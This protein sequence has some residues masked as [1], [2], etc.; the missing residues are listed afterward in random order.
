MRELTV[1]IVVAG[2]VTACQPDT[3]GEGD[4]A[5]G[6]TTDPSGD[7]GT[8]S[9][10][11]GSS[12]EPACEEPDAQVLWAQDGEAMDPMA[13]AD[14]NTLG[15]D[16]A[17]SWSAEQG[18]LT[19]QFSTEC[20]GP[21]HM[22]ALVWD[23]VGGVEMDNAD[24]LYFTIDDQDEQT[25]LYGCNT[26]GS[27]MGQWLWQSMD[28][29]TEEGCFHDLLDLELLAGDHTIVFRNREGG[30]GVNVASFAGVVWSH[31]PTADPSQFLEPP[32]PE[33]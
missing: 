23:S 4:S 5:A 33:R 25:W 18:T 10:G 2:W 3:E 32:I 29:W 1:A 20:D 6:A 9:E 15:V 7:T 22:W 19:L 27:S 28:A 24:S 12:G 21:I 14:G 31:D 13:I 16:V 8:A 11:S 26:P 30:M 17:R